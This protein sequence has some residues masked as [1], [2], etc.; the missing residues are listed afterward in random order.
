MNLSVLVQSSC[1]KLFCA[2][3]KKNPGG[4]RFLLFFILFKI[5]GDLKVRGQKLERKSCSAWGDAYVYTGLMD[6]L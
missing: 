1:E 2:C 3:N 5:L 4:D 6:V